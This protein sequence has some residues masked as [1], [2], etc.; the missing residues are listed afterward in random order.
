MARRVKFVG[1]CLTASL[2]LLRQKTTFTVTVKHLRA[3]MSPAVW[4]CVTL[5]VRQGILLTFMTTA[6]SQ[7]GE[8]MQSGAEAVTRICQEFRA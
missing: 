4:E 2:P 5:L 7:A 3:L 8:A 1:V 6:I